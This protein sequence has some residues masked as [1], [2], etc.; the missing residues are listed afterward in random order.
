MTMSEKELVSSKELQNR[1]H[2]W[3]ESQQELLYSEDNVLKRK[4][5]TEPEEFFDTDSEFDSVSEC[6]TKRR[7]VLKQVKDEVLNLLCEWKDCL[8]DTNSLDIFVKHVSNHIPQLKIVT[9]EEG[10]EV[11]ACLWNG[12]SFESDI[13]DDIAKHVNYHSYHTK[14]KCIG[15]NIRGRVKLPKCYQDQGLKNVIDQPLPQICSWEECLKSFNNYQAYLWHVVTHIETNPRGNKVEG[16]VNCLWTGCNG[17]YKSLYKLREHVRCHT[18]EKM[19]ACPD[20]G[21]TF[22]SNTKFHDHCKRQIPLDLQGFQCSHCNKYYPTESI[23]RNHM[24]F[25]VFHYKCT[26]CDMS[27]E[28]PASLAK[29]IRYRHISSRPFKCQLCT[30]AAKS[31]QDLDSHMAVHTRGPNFICTVDGCSYGCKNSYMMDR[32]MERVHSKFLRFYCCHECPVKYRKSY[33]L[34]KHLIETHHLQWPNGHKRFRYKKDEDGCYRLQVVRYETLDE[35]TVKVT[36]ESA[37]KEKNYLLELSAGSS[38][39]KLKIT[40]EVEKSLNSDYLKMSKHEAANETGK[41][42]PIVSNILIWIDE[43]DEDGNIIESRVVETQETNELPP[44]AEPPIIIK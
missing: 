9:T 16:G 6:G 18:K 27:C 43:V 41:S 17:N 29:H 14:L 2:G 11:Y 44:S 25:H 39:P 28:S 31:E 36:G 7:R 32:H 8:F 20:C 1:C 5:D 24:H 15:S 19:V 4:L 42:M 37:P 33:R 21:A 3:V 30:H 22:A 40:E 13:S 34:T 26:M 38:V 10:R 23:L 12:C 35:D